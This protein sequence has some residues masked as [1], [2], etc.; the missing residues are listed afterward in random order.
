MV[1]GNKNQQSGWQQVVSE[2]FTNPIFLIILALKL[3][4]SLI[5][6]SVI[7]A[8]LFVPFLSFFAENIGANPYQHFFNMGVENAFPYPPFMLILAG[9]PF[10]I[11]SLINNAGVSVL[12]L[13]L[14]RLPLLIA[15]IVILVV[16]TLLNTQRKQFVLLLYWASPIVFYIN[17][18]HGQLDILPVALLLV[19]LYALFQ[20]RL[21]L[22]ALLLGLGLSTKHSLLLVLPFIAFYLWRRK[23]DWQ[24]LSQYAGVVGF[25]YILLVLP[26][27]L[28][29][30][31]IG[32]VF[33]AQEQ[34][35]V[36]DLA[37]NF[38]G[39]L[40]FFVVIA[41]FFYLA[42]KAFSFRKITKNILFM[43]IGVT[44]TIFVTLVQ[45]QHGWYMWSIPFLVYFFAR[46]KFTS[47][48][49]YWGLNVMYFAYFF[50][51]PKSDVFRV[52]QVVAPGLAALPTPFAIVN[53][54]GFDSLLLL[55]I[56]YTV[57]SANLLYIAYLMYRYGIRSSLLFQE[58]DGIPVVGITGD[59]GTGKTVTADFIRNMLGKDNLNLVA[60]DDIHRWERG[61]KNWEKL[62][63]LNPVSN[64]I[65]YHYNHIAEL[66]KGKSIWR[67]T[68]DHNTGKFTPKKLIKP[69]HYI[70][71]EGLHTFVIEDTRHLYNLK[72]Y[73]DPN[74]ALKLYWK[75]K[76]DVA[77][78][79][80]SKQKV[81]AALSK[82]KIDS[83]KYISP[84]RKEADV[85]ISIQP[86][87]DVQKS[88]VI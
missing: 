77:E 46:Q 7:P 53:S 49:L 67:S 71:D 65:H 72:V 18:V 82:R 19:S 26:Y 59:S 42:F 36:F 38:S 66:K 33:G 56:V 24:T 78:R 70:V 6:I 41:L 16:L 81:L 88:C 12:D 21:L 35:Q 44:F 30:G 63:H 9:L 29:K 76:R 86:E 4:A 32:M 48:V 28:S 80:H 61:H 52:F 37:I 22:S 40:Q 57:L 31:F 39:G 73:M 47:H 1:G 2:L 15:D 69:R 54:L 5:F 45:P 74:P 83:Q 79:G 3:V 64:R 23:Y 13:F 14:L 10:F 75:I 58:E 55:S 25:V 8:E 51:I 50:F 87:G 60:G 11:F 68:Y 84:Q 27:V 43:F 34:F 17:Y 20:S 62:T 85:I